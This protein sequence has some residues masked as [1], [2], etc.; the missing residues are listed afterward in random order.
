MILILVYVPTKIVKK[1]GKGGKKLTI[2]K[3]NAISKNEI[4][5]F[6]DIPCNGDIFRAYYIASSYKLIKNET[7]ILGALLLKWLKESLITIEKKR[8]WISNKKR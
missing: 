7:D 8:N 3:N 6:R 2:K 1:N 5:Y 4:E